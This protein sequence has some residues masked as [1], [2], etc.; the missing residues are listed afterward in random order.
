MFNDGHFAAQ[1]R[2]VLA[3]SR[4]LVPKQQYEKRLQKYPD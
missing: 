1:G 2:R 4:E 3:D